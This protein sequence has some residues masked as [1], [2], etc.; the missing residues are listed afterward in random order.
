MRCGHVV[1]HAGSC[2]VKFHIETIFPQWRHVFA[3]SSLRSSSIMNSEESFRVSCLF[4]SQ[5]VVFLKGLRDASAGRF[6]VFRS[7][8]YYSEQLR[9]WVTD[10][11]CLRGALALRFPGA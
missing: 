4:K 10:E 6:F 1:L 7:T 2:I 8:T 11:P 5:S 9:G 3:L